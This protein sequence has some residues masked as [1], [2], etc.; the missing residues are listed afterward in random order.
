LQQYDADPSITATSV[1]SHPT[2]EQAFYLLDGRARFVV[3][4]VEREVGAGELVFAPRHVKHGYKV[5]G[6]R[7]V[8]W[9]MMAWSS[10]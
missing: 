1:H 5:V 6:D 10:E 3:G 9:L 2:S 8:K 4:D 7:P